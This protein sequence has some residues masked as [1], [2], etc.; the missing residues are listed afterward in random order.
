LTSSATAIT[1]GATTG[2]ST[3]TTT[4]KRRRADRFDTAALAVV[5]VPLAAL[6]AL[7]GA[8]PS[9]TLPLL[10]FASAVFLLTG[11]Q[12]P[13][14]GPTRTLD[15]ALVAALAAIALPLLPLPVDLVHLISPHA[16]AL[17]DRLTI[18]AGTGW[19]PLSID[20]DRTREALA[21][22]AT[23]V[24]VFWAARRVFARGGTRLA[25]RTVA[26]AGF[27]VSLIALVQRATAPDLLLWTW[28]PIDPGAQ[29]FGPFVNRNH[30]GT[31]LLMAAALSAGLAVAHTRMR[32]LIAGSLRQTLHRTLADGTAIFLA[33]A[34]AIMLLT[35]ISSLSRGAVA[36]A[37][38]AIAFGL[39]AGRSRARGSAVG[40]AAA[41]TVA[42]V[43][44]A[45]LWLNMTG[46]LARLDTGGT[47]S[48][49]T[50]W[51][52]T[53]DVVHDFPVTGTGAGTYARSMLIYQRAGRELLYNQAHNEYLQLVAEGGVLLAVPA[54]A[55]VVAWV[56]LARRR[57]RED[58]RELF[59]IRLAA[60]A[61]LA[62]VAV[63]CFG[64]STLRMPAN[65]T[66]L[67]LLAGLVVHEPSAE[68]VTANCD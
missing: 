38:V 7:G 11:G 50:I 54:A 39:V 64:E 56:A 16:A 48:R 40:T 33:A 37:T 2:T 62:G 44:A 45:G 52:N 60:A 14:N 35:L 26:V 46:L 6:A 49:V 15:L 59:W 8:Y 65:A 43:M 67:A 3:A 68:P 1:T 10:I 55:A 20:P 66:L 42:A 18:G 57:L 36:A 23:A 32:A 27:V 19:R 17:Q 29:P 47:S 28:T 31:W 63:Q 51:T 5:A 53:L 58:R 13:G 12:S 4:A 34:S 24:F 25:A 21:S 61:A 22:A 9:S 30:F 41:L